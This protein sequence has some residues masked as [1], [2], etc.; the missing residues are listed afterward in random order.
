[1]NSNLSNAFAKN[2]ENVNLFYEVYEKNRK[3]E[4]DIKY[5]ENGIKSIHMIL[6]PEYKFYL[7]LNTVFKLLHATKELP[8]IK[9]NL[10]NTEKIFRFYV[11]NVL[12]CFGFIWTK[13]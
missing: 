1:M 12:K 4:G 8:M 10:A 9:M 7:P 3:E 5:I 2:V 6:K 11:D 13:V